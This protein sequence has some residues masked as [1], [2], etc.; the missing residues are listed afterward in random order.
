MKENIMRPT[1]P[2]DL[3]G[4]TVHM[5]FGGKKLAVDFSSRAYKLSPEHDL[6][7]HFCMMLLAAYEQGCVDGSIGTQNRIKHA[8]GINTTNNL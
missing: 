1:L 6:R 7:S 4:D 8:L 5:H 2:F 3:T